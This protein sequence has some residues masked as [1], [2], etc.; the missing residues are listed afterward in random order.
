MKPSAMGTILLLLA[1][2][3]LAAPAKAQSWPPDFERL[4]VAPTESWNR[5]VALAFAP[6]GRIFV[7]EKR[8]TVQVLLPDP[9][10][11]DP[12]T[13]YVKAG[14]PFLDIR[15]DVLDHWDRGLLGLALDPDFDDN[16]WVYVAYIVETDPGNPDQYQ[17]SYTRVERFQVSAADSN[18]ADLSTRQVLVGE[19]WPTGIT[20]AHTSHTTGR[21]VFGD[22]KTL[23]IS[24]GDGAH[25]DGDD[26]GGRDPQQFL[27]G[28][29]DPI[30]DVGAFRSQFL[31]SLSGKVLRVDKETGD[32]LPSNPWYDSGAPRSAASR[33]WALGLR[34][35]YR[36]DI[37]R[38]SGSTDPADGNPGRLY[39]GDVGYTNWEEVNVADGGENFGWPCYEGSG[40]QASYQGL[41]PMH[42]D[43]PPDDSGM[44]PPLLEWPHSG[45]PWDSQPL[46]GL[47][48]NAAT[49]AALHQGTNYPLRYRNI[50]YFCDY[51]ANWIHGVRLDASDAPA[52]IIPF[53][54]GMSQPVDLR[55]DPQSGDLFYLSYGSNRIYRFSYAGPSGEGEDPPQPTG[56]V[57]TP[58]L[59][60]VELTWVFSPVLDVV[61][62]N[63]YRS[64]DGGQ[65]WSKI[66]GSLVTDPSFVDTGGSTP[67]LPGEIYHY[68]VEAVDGEEP[69]RTSPLS[70]PVALAVTAKAWEWYAPF[71]GASF[72]LDSSPAP[73]PRTLT[74]ENPS[75]QDFDHW[76]TADRAPQ[77]RR[78]VSGDFTLETRMTMEAFT[79]G[80]NFHSGLMVGFGQ[81][82]VFYWGFHRGT[83]L[84]MERTGNSNLAN[85][86]YSSPSVWLRVVK[87]GDTY[88]FE[89]R[90]QE[91]DPWTV[92]ATR[93][94]STPVQFVGSIL[95]TWQSNVDIEVRLDHLALDD[96]TPVADASA[97]PINGP[98]PLDVQFS[99]AS[100]DADGDLL[101][102]SWDLGD[103]QT[104]NAVSPSHSYG[105]VGDYQVVLEVT[106]AVG[107]TARDTL[108]VTAEGNHAPTASITEPADGFEFVFPDSAIALTAEATDLEDDPANLV[109]DWSVDLVDSLGTTPG[110]LTP[111]SGAASS[112]VPGTSGRV[113]LDVILTVTDSGGLSASDTVRVV[114]ASLPPDP[115]L[116]LRAALADGSAPPTVPGAASPWVNLVSPGSGPHAQ[117]QGFDVPSAEEGWQ[118]SGVLGDP[119]RLAFDGVDGVAVVAAGAIDSLQSPSGASVE[120]WMRTPSDVQT[121]AYVLEWLEDYATPFDG[122]TLALEQGELRLYR[123]GWTTLTAIDPATWL[124][125]IVAKGADAWSVWV[126]GALVASGSAP[127]L[128]AQS[129]E[130]VLGAGT[131][132]G[133]GQYSNFFG[134]EIAE[135]RVY[136]RQL[137]AANVQVL[138]A[139]AD[140]VYADSPLITSLTPST[141]YDDQD[142]VDL[143]VEGR[144]FQDGAN[145]RATLEGEPDLVATS[146]EFVSPTQ[147]LVGLPTTG[148][149]VGDWDLVVSNPDGLSD[150]LEGALAVRRPEAAYLVFDAARADGSN[151]PA[152]PGS[153]SPWVDSRSGALA[154]LFGF[155]G[156]VSSGWQGDGA[157]LGPYRLRFDGVD[158]RA[159]VDSLALAPSDTVLSLEIWCAAGSDVQTPQVVV[160]QGHDGFEGAEGWNGWNG[161]LLGIVEGEYRVQVNQ[162]EQLISLGPAQPGVFTQLAL[163]VSAD[164]LALFRDGSLVSEHVLVSSPLTA[165]ELEIG[166]GRDGAGDAD[167][168]FGG[169][170]AR[171]HV[172]SRSLAPVDVS[173]SHALHA[174]QFVA[175]D[176]AR[177]SL[178]PPAEELRDGQPTAVS[179]HWDDQGHAFPLRALQ[180]R[181][182]WDPTTLGLESWAEGAL[183][184]VNGV[185]AFV[186][187]DTSLAGEATFDLAAL[188]GALVGAGSLLDLDY[189]ALGGAP[190]GPTAIDVEIL[191]VV[192]TADPPQAI[193]TLAVGAT[194]SIDLTPPSAVSALAASA[195]AGQV[196]LSW[197]PPSTDYAGARI[198]VRPWTTDAEQGHPEYDDLTP[199]PTWPST[200]EEARDPAQE[201]TELVVG[202][203]A[204]SFLVSHPQRSVLSV[205][206]VSQDPAGNLAD[207]T[208]S[209]R[210]RAPTYPLGDVGRL[211]DTGQRVDEFDGAVDGVRDLPVFSRAYDTLDGA[212]GY[213]AVCDIG[214]TA[215]GSMDSAPATDDRVDFEDLVVFSQ[216]FGFSTLAKDG[217]AVLSLGRAASGPLQLR[218]G[219]PELVGDPGAASPD[220]TLRLPLELSGN[221]GRV[222]A[223]HLV[224]DYDTEALELQGFE[225][226]GVLQRERDAVLTFLR[227]A[228]RGSAVLDLCVLG[229]RAYFDGD[230]RLGTLHFSVK[231][232]QSGSLQLREADLRGVDGETLGFVT[233]GLVRDEVVPHPT[234]TRLLAAT[235]NPFNP[236]TSLRFELARESR[237]RLVVY[238]VSGRR[239]R[240]LVDR[241]MPAGYHRVQWQGVDE[242]GHRVSSGVYLYE[243]V[244]DGGHRSVQK[245]MLV[246]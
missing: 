212:A 209:P 244:T 229:E 102:H 133:A 95:K 11:A 117:L 47:I 45:R 73:F 20:S 129:S 41:D 226:A 171:L 44:T 231:D 58:G 180:L 241:R 163:N 139:V 87:T 61:G 207:L 234:Q 124:H 223:V 216:T 12:R 166:A 80:R 19:T 49:G 179:V 82:D 136:D 219:E 3:L 140:A 71:P 173:D 148:A 242:R 37:V 62:Y 118:G 16:G 131:F 115:V 17:W 5:P 182:S 66:N 127:H 192:D 201:W 8:G 174:P 55:A 200:L 40:E 190:E 169:D 57:A 177:L 98:T 54:T 154:T 86:S 191:Q 100:F 214:P 168:H 114:D 48:G 51:S 178:Q 210:L 230:G 30:E 103:G 237:V 204:S 99:S 208:S 125:V 107:L 132:A 64:T 91:S 135:L 24:H 123:D 31:G 79:V 81:F 206:V 25:F 15:A 128:G 93:T 53:A 112:F 146:V 104:S 119:W 142:A 92:G 52:E 157:L 186:S 188:G 46:P 233:E 203:G 211:D 228:G 72:S 59:G 121:R 69:A 108:T 238:D 220:A 176:A 151:P 236:S 194:R 21:L 88:S 164:S 246:K 130:L 76:T 77:L 83:D 185:T 245:M 175:P 162:G 27:A 9:G 195:G 155:D 29:T 68:A 196:S 42:S 13:G 85:V 225:A 187:A 70:D 101:F 144:H 152:V 134:G 43:C 56:V 235:P 172:G 215:D 2:T 23:L 150:R 149:T 22:D 35:P 240:T 7:A 224:L 126:D 106:D 28:R 197:Q 109:Y 239:V 4:H 96:L 110:Y 1:A 33:T 153:A 183:F 38:G 159:E 63:V 184:T 122:M 213:D 222:R 232:G 138:G 156:D 32:G 221:D 158:D 181:L 50:L 160:R 60:E 39:I 78:D 205:I 34:N 36:M 26:A 65:S 189:E 217:S 170:L 193:P 198:F 84:R 94:T 199:A 111:P 141:V 167:A 6:D 90:A 120:L 89:Y 145:V 67:I 243:L 137:S 165:S 10:A 74:L 227:P 14:S 105:D 113:A 218:G 116:E 143:V 147:L 18:Q 97:T 161:W 75:S 202:M